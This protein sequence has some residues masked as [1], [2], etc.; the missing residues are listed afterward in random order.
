MLP[1]IERIAR[2]KESYIRHCHKVCLSGIEELVPS[3]TSKIQ[4]E[5]KKMLTQ[6]TITRPSTTSVKTLKEHISLFPIIVHLMTV[7]LLRLH[8]FSP[9]FVEDLSY[10]LTH[11]ESLVFL[12]HDEF[13]S[14]LLLILEAISQNPSAISSQQSSVIL[15]LLPA[16]LGILF[17]SEN[18]DTRFLCLKIFI[19]VISELYGQPVVQSLTHG[20]SN[21]NVNQKNL[22][23]LITK[24][25]LPNY[26]KLL[27]E[28][29]PIPPFAL[30]LLNIILEKNLSLISLV[31]QLNL[32]HFFFDFFELQ[33]PNNNIHNIRLIKKVI[34]SNEVEKKVAY[35]ARLI[36]KLS[37]VFIYSYEKGVDS[38]LE[39]VLDIVLHLLST[40]TE[41]K[42]GTEFML[43]AN[44]PLVEF[45]KI[46]TLLLSH[47]DSQIHEKAAAI[48][49]LLPRVYPSF[50]EIFLSREVNIASWLSKGSSIQKILLASLK[51]IV[52]NSNLFSKKVA[53]LLREDN[54]IGVLQKLKSPQSQEILEILR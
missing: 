11:A 22:H 7:P 16:L 29:D 21:E 23:A 19:D 2:E 30:K 15:H 48:L 18:G 31:S 32:T 49:S 17:K 41:K 20:S 53:V 28:E 36:S 50:S 27:K 3:I 12:A 43:S 10:F 6:K 46:Y 51:Y 42:Q 14:H 52:S 44:Q 8:A 39:L 47:P 26:A 25:L 24:Q 45:Y 38:F 37:E 35:E 54:L 5:I 33:H 34:E 13:Q 9:Q 4:T 40:S 1:V